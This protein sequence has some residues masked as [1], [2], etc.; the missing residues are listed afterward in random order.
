VEGAVLA[1]E[2]LADHAGVAVDQNG[3]G[4]SLLQAA[5]ADGADDLLGG[6]V[7]VFRRD[8]VEARVADDLLALLDV[9]TLR[10]T[11]SGTCRPTVFH[12]REHAAGDH[13]ALHDAAEDVDENALH[14]R[15]RGDDLE[16]RGDLLLRG[17]AAHIEEVRGLLA[18]EL[19][20]V[21]GRHG[22]A[23]AVHHAADGAIERDV[24]EVVLGG[25]DLLLVLLREVAERD[26]FRVTVEGVR[27]E[28]D[29]RVQALQVPV[30]GDDERVDLQHA[31]VAGHE[32]LEELGGDVLGLLGER[33]R[34]AQRLGDRP[35][36]VGHHAGGGIDREGQDLLRGVVGHLL[37]V[38]AALCRDHI[39]MRPVSRSTSMER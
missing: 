24:G 32:G 4:C 23:G 38:H 8:D 29:L 9:G 31:H 22:E 36:V 15:V 39:A 34:E 7:E 37:D 13:V 6:V 27:V 18:V 5:R 28:G 35:P 17:A 3:H 25:L 1:R 14:L 16:G 30:R 2:P 21:E 10:R 20:D 26:D 19:D 12:R 33:A 11:T